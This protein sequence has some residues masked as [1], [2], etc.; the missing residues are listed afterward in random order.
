MCGREWG[1]GGELGKMVVQTRRVRGRVWG[2]TVVGR[3]DES[4]GDGC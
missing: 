3:G 1:G 2:E 4:G